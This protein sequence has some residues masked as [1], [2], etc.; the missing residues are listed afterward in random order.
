MMSKFKLIFLLSIIPS[1]GWG[2]D[3][4]IDCV[5]TLRSHWTYTDNHILVGQSGT[6]RLKFLGNSCM[7][8]QVT[9][10]QVSL[11]CPRFNSSVY[12]G[13]RVQISFRQISTLSKK[14]ELIIDSNLIGQCNSI[15]S[16]NQIDNDIDNSLKDNTNNPM[17][18]LTRPKP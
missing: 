9:D 7:V 5:D 15:L 3:F 16:G 1:V 10:R 4:R 14:G 18:R 8:T 17:S 13:K 2:L 11:Y 12:N 6:Y